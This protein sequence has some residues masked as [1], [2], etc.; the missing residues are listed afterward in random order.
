MHRLR[1]G[2]PTVWLL[3]LSQIL[4]YGTIY[5][6]VA[7]LAPGIAADLGWETSWILGA[8]SAGLLAS[9]FASPFAGRCLDRHGAGRVMTVGSISVAA[10]LAAQS[11]APTAVLFALALVASQIAAPFV[12]YNAAF[13]YLAQ[14]EGQ[15]ARRKIVLLT[16]IA[17]F[18]ST[19]FWPLTT[20]LLE[21]F[22]WREILAAFALANLLV[23]APLHWHLHR[24]AAKAGGGRTAEAA[25]ASGAP[26][27]LGIDVEDRRLPPGLVRR[28]LV[29][30]TAGFAISGFMY[31]AVLAQMVP[32]LGAVGIGAAAVT[33]A[34]LFGPSQVLIRVGNLIGARNSHP[35]MATLLACTLLPVAVLLLAATAPSVP[36]AIGFV[37]LFGFGSGLTSIV[38]GTLP[39]ALF[40]ASGYGAVLGRI[41][42]VQLMAASLAPFA[43][44]ASIDTLGTAA[45]LVG[46]SVIGFA[47]LGCFL[48]LSRLETRPKLPAG[49]AIGELEGS[50][51]L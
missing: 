22:S 19:L 21:R 44:S 33:V 18:A 26:N 4:A 37:V 28:G 35:I 27:P 40:G 41:T 23:C 5:Y 3:G 30:T 25:T 10:A 7:I 50:H 6:S 11:L 8:F 48:V 17:G 34:A 45:S 42:A 51:G 39:L 1:W 43:L 36:G 46:L 29:L 49:S 12:Q 20:T 9:G 13:A 16:L 32:L 15:G 31:S 38:R 14:A 24:R 2:S 47:G